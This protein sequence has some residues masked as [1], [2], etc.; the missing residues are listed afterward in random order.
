MRNVNNL[1]VPA[2]LDRRRLSPATHEHERPGVPVPGHLPDDRA[3]HRDGPRRPQQAAALVQAAGQPAGFALPGQPL[4]PH[5]HGHR[6]PG[7]GGLRHHSAGVVR[8]RKSQC[9][10]HT[11]V[12]Q[13]V[14]RGRD[15]R[16]YCI[17]THTCI[18][19]YVCVCCVCIYI[20]ICVYICIYTVCVD[21]CLYVCIY[22]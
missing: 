22:I 6:L 21:K 4:P 12:S 15:I 5:L 16:I 13:L 10:I 20:F 7:G 9:I 17:Y 2:R 11:S 14:G 18:Y 19:T 3:G 1:A 8:Q